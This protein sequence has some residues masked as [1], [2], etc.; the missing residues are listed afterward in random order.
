MK[1]ILKNLLLVLF[2]FSLFAALISLM[3]YQLQNT[4]EPYCLGGLNPQICQKNN[5]I[6]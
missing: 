1:S 4:K 3:I 6:K 2:S 5:P